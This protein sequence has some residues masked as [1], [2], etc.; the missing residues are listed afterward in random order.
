MINDNK[1]ADQTPEE[2]TSFLENRERFPFPA[3][4][5]N[6]R[7]K[8]FCGA[9]NQ[10]IRAVSG[11][12]VVILNAD[13]ILAE[14]FAAKLKELVSFDLSRERIGI[15]APKILDFEGKIDSAGL[16]LT[17]LRR[18]RDRGRGE[19]GSGRY[20]SACRVFGASGAC[21]VYN[22]NMLDSI[23]GPGGFF[24]EDFFIMLEDFDVSWRQARLGWHTLYSPVLNCKHKGGISHK[25]TGIGR[26]FMFRNRYFLLAKN[27][28]LPRLALLLLCSFFY[29]LPHAVFF[30][31]TNPLA[32]G[33]IRQTVCMLPA[34]I[35][36][37]K[38]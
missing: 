5:F 13:V 19:S 10:G 15:F 38:S 18:F 21:A 7:N 6:A 35:R 8:G 31:L 32:S 20:D 17:F 24:D 2:I 14:D 16:C 29:D 30:I 1:S 11:E 22:R 26:A 28:S 36:K 25:K 34:M 27:E 3:P 9:A 37:R 4:V 12:F 33:F 23:R